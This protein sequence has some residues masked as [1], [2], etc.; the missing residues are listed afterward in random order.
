MKMKISVMLALLILFSASMVL[1]EG[2]KEPNATSAAAQASQEN[3]DPATTQWVW[4]EVTSVDTQ[5]KVI[6][7]KYL[8]YE[9]DQEKE[10]SITVDDSTSYDNIMSLEE[11]QPK[12]YLSIDYISEDG[13]HIARTIGLEKAEGAPT[14]NKI[15]AGV[16]V[17]ETNQAAPE[18]AAPQ[19]AEAN[20]PETT[21]QA[22]Q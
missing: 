2:Q 22:P 19:Q 14:Q 3:S 7:L 16:A 11:I 10:T 21:T 12:D 5:N 1:S 15:D 4:G 8:D 18:E 13:K 20:N 6:A 17:P 9:T